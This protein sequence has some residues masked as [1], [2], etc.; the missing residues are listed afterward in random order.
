MIKAVARIVISLTIYCA[1]IWSKTPFL[2]HIRPSQCAVMI[3]KRRFTWFVYPVLLDL[4]TVVIF[5]SG[6]SKS[7]SIFTFLLL[8]SLKKSKH[9]FHVDLHSFFQLCWLLFAPV[10]H[11]YQ[12]DHWKR[13]TQK[14]YDTHLL[15][16]VFDSLLCK[17]QRCLSFC[18]ALPSC[19]LSA[20][21]CNCVIFRCCLVHFSLSRVKFVRSARFLSM[22][23]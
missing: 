13:Q 4:E 18:H 5:S 23:M 17:S 20:S 3:M 10:L 16:Q 11:Q 1:C 15:W 9:P 21:C 7:G 12:P 19:F 8:F 6:Y 14:S 22:L 2:R